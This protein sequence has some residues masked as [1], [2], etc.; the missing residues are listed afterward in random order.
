MS[1]NAVNKRMIFEKMKST[2]ELV[3][4]KSK[5]RQVIMSAF[6]SIQLI[7]HVW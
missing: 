6:F 3:D 5:I 4:K 2:Y 7:W 1:K